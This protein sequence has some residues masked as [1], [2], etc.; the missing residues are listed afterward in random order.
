[1]TSTSWLAAAARS[2]GTGLDGITRRESTIVASSV[3]LVRLGS[4]L[5]RLSRSLDHDAPA[6]AWLVHI[7][8]A[9]TMSPC[10]APRASLSVCGL[11]IHGR[12]FAARRTARRGDKATYGRPD[13][14][15]DAQAT[16]RSAS[17]DTLEEGSPRS[18]A[19]RLP[20]MGLYGSYGGMGGQAHLRGAR[21]QV[22][23][24]GHGGVPSAPSKTHHRAPA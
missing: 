5:A 17:G 11:A 2:S 22:S 23:A 1:V 6:I 21:R 15:T 12:C 9:Q 18:A 13:A 19:A 3:A 24:A 20:A 8:F 4:P 7:G 16:A 10:G 14:L